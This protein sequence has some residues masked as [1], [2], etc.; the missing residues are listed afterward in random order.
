[1]KIKALR[2]TQAG[3]RVLVAGKTYDDLDDADA[4]YL[5]RIGK[6]E[7]VEDKKKATAPA[8]G[9]SGDNTPPPAS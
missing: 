9:S 1:M 3:S 2:N 6:A 8:G 7:E 5:I 4:K